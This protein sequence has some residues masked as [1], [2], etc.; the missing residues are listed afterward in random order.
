[1]AKKQVM[2]EKDVKD[3]E[4]EKAPLPKPPVLTSKPR[5]AAT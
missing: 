4:R 2:A 1:M 3:A 5:R